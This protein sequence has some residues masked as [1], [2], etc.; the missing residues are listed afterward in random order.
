MTTLPWNNAS[1]ASPARASLGGRVK[2]D[3]S[4]RSGPRR[5]LAAA[6]QSEL[7]KA[8]ATSLISQ[9]NDVKEE[10]RGGNIRFARILLGQP[11]LSET[12]TCCCAT[13]TWPRS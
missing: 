5:G 3:P 1:N 8:Y 9:E 7:H 11:D 13:L 4:K 12:L 2:V 10:S 6:Q